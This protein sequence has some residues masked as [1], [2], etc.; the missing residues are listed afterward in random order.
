MANSW[1][2]RTPRVGELDKNHPAFSDLLKFYQQFARFQQSLAEKLASAPEHDLPALLPF[3]PQLISLAKRQGSPALA[4]AAATLEQDS[5]EDRL[6]LLEAVWQHQV[7][8]RH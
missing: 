1:D 4:A 2:L 5:P 3:F 6:G 7:E 8:S